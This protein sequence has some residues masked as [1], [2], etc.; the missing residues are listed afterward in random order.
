M[1]TDIKG[2]N[3]I[4]NADDFG[5]SESVNCAIIQLFEKGL[6]DRTTIITNGLFYDDAVRFSLSNNLMGKVGLHINLDSGIPLSEPIK[7]NKNF[8]STDGVFNGNF[9]KSIFKR[10]VLS[11]EDIKC[12]EEELRAQIQKFLNSGFYSLHFDSHHHVHN[13]LSIL[14]IIIPIAKN[15]NFKSSRLCRN[16]FDTSPN[17][18]KLRYKFALNKMIKSNFITTDFFGS[19]ADWKL[20][21]NNLSSSDVEIMVHPDIIESS[22]VDITGESSYSKIE[23]YFI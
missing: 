3:I 4:I 19:Y 14:K 9:K 7:K 8:C 17:K 6:I 1:S 10:F 23:D 16:L 20:N 11:K 18:L 21:Q 5:L 22:L 2:K 15:Y 12:V 13:Y